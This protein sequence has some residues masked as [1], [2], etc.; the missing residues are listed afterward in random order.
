MDLRSR[1]GRTAGAP[2]EDRSRGDGG[3]RRRARKITP[4]LGRRQVVA[5]VDESY[6]WDVPSW[7]WTERGQPAATGRRVPGAL[8]EIAVILDDGNVI[9]SRPKA[10]PLADDSTSL[11]GSVRADAAEPAGHPSQP[12][13]GYPGVFPLMT[14]PDPDPSTRPH[15]SA[16]TSCAS[17]GHGGGVALLPHQRHAA[18]DRG[19]HRAL[20]PT[21]L[22]CAC[23]WQRGAGGA[24]GRHGP[25]GRREVERRRRSRDALARAEQSA[26]PAADQPYIVIST[27]EHELWYKKERTSSSI[28]GRHRRRETTLVREGGGDDVWKFETPRGRLSVISKEE[29]PVWQPPDWHYVEQAR[30]RQAGL[31]R[32]ERGQSLWPRPT[33]PWVSV[34]GN[35]V[36]RRARDGTQTTLTRDGRPRD[37]RGRQTARP[38]RRHDRSAVTKACWAPAA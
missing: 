29:D 3:T 15:P 30:K 12:Q 19:Q 38:A 36:V 1:R 28:P 33:A 27:E 17:F 7:V 4:P 6:A 34:S 11:P 32:L 14:T 8:G 35:D 13:R 5:V 25:A 9:Y 31:V 18:R 2:R 21:P 20:S 37:H 24:G 16:R 10:G 23:S 22:P 26:A